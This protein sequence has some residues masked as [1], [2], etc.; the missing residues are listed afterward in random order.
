MFYQ[1]KGDSYDQARER[2]I[3]QI[4]I[5]QLDKITR[6]MTDRVINKDLL[7]D[8]VLIGGAIGAS[9]VSG[10]FGK[11]FVCSIKTIF[12]QTELFCQPIR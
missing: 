9:G 7:G 12:S 11:G 8:G 3:S 5:D 10:G 4:D 1:M 6:K 2:I